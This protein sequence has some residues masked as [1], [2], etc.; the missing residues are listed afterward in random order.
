[1]PSGREESI[2]VSLFPTHSL[3]P[4]IDRRWGPLTN[5]ELILGRKLIFITKEGPGVRSSQRLSHAAGT[6]DI[7]STAC[8]A[9]A[10][11][12][13]DAHKLSRDACGAPGIGHARPQGDAAKARLD[14]RRGI[15]AHE[16]H[17]DVEAEGDDQ[18]Q[19]AEAFA[20][21]CLA[22]GR[23]AVNR[24]RDETVFGRVYA[25][26]GQCE[27]GQR[28]ATARQHN[29]RQVGDALRAEV[30]LFR[31]RQRHEVPAAGVIDAEGCGRFVEGG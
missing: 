14:L 9:T 30:A 15:L 22:L 25:A 18:V 17:G 23:H 6:A 29:A 16:L 1:M 3:I 12:F 4:P 28:I 2:Q 13:Y 21:V 31:G 19:H 27:L 8:R 5:K 26:S 20:G 7:S 10:A 11:K 24:T